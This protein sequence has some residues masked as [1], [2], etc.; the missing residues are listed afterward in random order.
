MLFNDEKINKSYSCTAVCLVR[1]QCG[2]P[3]SILQGG[4]FYK[5]HANDEKLFNYLKS[6]IIK[7]S[8]ELFKTVLYEIS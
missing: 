6:L 3:E 2:K 7:R 8:L 5:D 4:C 1:P